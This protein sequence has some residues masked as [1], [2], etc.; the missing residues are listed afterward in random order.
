MSVPDIAYNDYA[1]AIEGMYNGMDE[2]IDNHAAETILEW[3]KKAAEKK[4]QIEA[5][6]PLTMV[7]GDAH[8]QL[9]DK[10]KAKEM[11]DKAFQ[12]MMKS[13]Q[14]QFIQTLQPQISKRIQALDE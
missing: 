4:P 1:S 6:A 5:E 14:Q 13:Q 3:G 11:Y 10:V 2:K 8:K 7:M 9:G 12:I